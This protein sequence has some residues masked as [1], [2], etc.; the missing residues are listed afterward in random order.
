M[1][2]V[3]L[4]NGGKPLIVACDSERG[5]IHVEGGW[6]KRTLDR[7]MEMQL[8]LSQTFKLIEGGTDIVPY[9]MGHLY[10]HR[11]RSCSGNLVG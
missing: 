4:E 9:L 2:S 6:K 10:R 1:A 3:N 11:L 5:L 8:V 7:Y